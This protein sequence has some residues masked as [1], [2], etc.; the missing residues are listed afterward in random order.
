MDVAERD[1]KL[2]PP[3]LVDEHN[4]PLDIRPSTSWNQQIDEIS[5]VE[6][7][8]VKFYSVLNKS[9]IEFAEIAKNAQN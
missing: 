8:E 1:D 2:F 6:L 4:E 3:G 5:I 9:R 7:M